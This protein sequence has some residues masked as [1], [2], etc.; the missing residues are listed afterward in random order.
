MSSKRRSSRNKI[1]VKP[2]MLRVSPKMASNVSQYRKATLE[3]DIDRGVIK[4]GVS[5]QGSNLRKDIRAPEPGIESDGLNR[6]EWVPASHGKSRILNGNS[7]NSIGAVAHSASF[8][9]IIKQATGASSLSSGS[10]TT[11][12]SNV[13]RL[14]PEVYSPLFTMANLN[15]PRDRITVNAWCFLP[16]TMICMSDGTQKPIKDINIGDSVLSSDGTIQKVTYL[17]KREVDEEIV[18]TQIKGTQ[19]TIWSTKN[20]GFKAIKSDEVR[21]CNKSI[22]VKCKPGDSDNKFCKW[23]NREKD[24]YIFNKIAAGDLERRDIVYSPILKCEPSSDNILNSPVGMELLGY[25]A[26]EGS[27][28]RNTGIYFSFGGHEKEVAEYVANELFKIWGGK[29]KP[30]VRERLNKGSIQVEYHNKEAASF[31]RYHC[32]VGS[33]TKC[34][35]RDL[36]SALPCNLI[37][38]LKAWI[39]GDGCQE[40]CNGGIFSGSTCSED[41]AQQIRLLSLRCGLAAHIFYSHSQKTSHFKKQNRVCNCA[42]RYFVK[43]RGKSAIK[44]A[45]SFADSPR[46]SRFT[47][48]DRD[49][50]RDGVSFIHNDKLI[51][52][53]NVIEYKQYCGPVYNIEVSGNHTYVAENI[54][55]YN[56]R[57]FFQLHPIVRNAITLHATYPISKLNIK[58]HDKRVLEF[59]EDMVEE[60]NLLESLGDIALEYFKLGECFPF[61]ELDEESGKWAKIIIQNPDYIHVKKTVLSG[62][63]VISLKPDAVLQRL[64]MSSNPAD[65]QLRKQ[66]PEKVIHHVRKGQDI[67]LDN[68][69]VSHLKMLSSPYDVRGTSVIVGV[70]KDLMLYDKLREAKFAQADGL[71]NPITIIK[72]G[73]NTDGDYRATSEDI[74]FFRQIFEEAQYDKD[75]KLI[76]HAGVTVERVGANGQ[77]LDIGPDMELIIKNIYTGLMVPPAVVDTESSVYASAS[78]GLEV[79]RQRYFN[80][81][82]MMAQW[83]TNKIFAPISQIQNFY[84]Y[85]DGKKKLIVPEVEWNQMNLYDL[86]DYIGN[87]TGLVGNKQVSLQTLYKSLGLS[88]QD[89]RVK[90]RQE[91]INDAIKMKE[92]QS[93]TGMTISELRTLDPEK[94]IADPVDNK[95]REGAAGAVPP[96]AGGMPG[97]MPG[98]DMGALPGGMPGELAAPPMGG[99]EMG[100]EMGGAPGGPGGL[101]DLGPGGGGGG[102]V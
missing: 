87:I 40:K 74:E 35:S 98:G 11:S 36:I 65:I 88:Y 14:A 96:E 38:F 59:F 78:I 92:E 86:Q 15:L 85:K 89:E 72:V 31:F 24:P 33:K 93:L 13:E 30:I 41:M 94:E 32:G 1:V 25:Y 46:T 90:M 63:P 7:E 45:Q 43:I 56:C 102:P 37:W 17:F 8:R 82:N 69:N 81:R 57:N 95:E 47:N 62:D 68:F 4:E 3:E 73:G 52:W 44:L 49:Y 80:F 18:G 58:C 20:H 55:V 83:L 50:N 27:L 97:G 60:M 77:I 42:P 39:D 5:Y 16:E 9:D 12:G 84:E 2:Q 19:N 61:A 34:L 99:G 64:V 51:Q 70:F 79:L 23:C 10:G 21:C 29:N 101:P 54:A 66:I 53:I 6:G 75:F 22:Y 91:A 48:I 26:A 76:T 28:S 67:P 71:V 100:G